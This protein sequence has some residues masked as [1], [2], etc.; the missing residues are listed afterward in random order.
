VFHLRPCH[1][2]LVLQK[3]PGHLSYIIIEKS[4]PPDSSLPGS[5]LHQVCTLKQW[6]PLEPSSLPANMFLLYAKSLHKRNI[7]KRNVSNIILLSPCR[8]SVMN[9]CDVLL[10]SFLFRHSIAP[11]LRQAFLAYWDHKW[12]T[13]GC[14]IQKKE[15][16][17]IFSLAS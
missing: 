1:V 3:G 2:P 10:H 9:N 8:E 17:A 7:S 13:L 12:I 15:N 6:S 4:Q 16:G 11:S 14:E 5:P